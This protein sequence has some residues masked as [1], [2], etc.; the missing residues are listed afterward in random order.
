MQRTRISDLLLATFLI[1]NLI[2]VA[3]ALGADATAGTSGASTERLYGQDRIA[4]SI[5]ASRQGW[6]TSDTVILNELTNYADAISATPF[7]VQLD[8]PVLL[9]P[10]DKLDSRVIEELKR[11]KTKRIILLGGNG[12]LTT[13]IEK[14]LT[15]LNYT[16]ERIGGADRYE[17]SALIAQKVTSDSM[18]LVNG[19]DFPDALSA[20]SYAGIEQIPI[21]LMS[22]P[23]FPKSV[24]N[25]YQAKKPSQVIVVGGE[26]VVPDKLLEEQNIPIKVRLGGKDRYETD[27]LLYNYAQKSYTSNQLYLASGEQYPDAMV[28]TVLAAKN[29]SALL[30]T[31]RFEMP[32][33]IAPM[34]N[35]QKISNMKV[36]ILGGTGVVSGRIQAGIEGKD[37]NQVLLIGKTVVVDPGHGSPDPGA[38]GPSGTLEKDNNL[39]I[40]Q[41]L[42]E[43]LKTAGAKVVLSRTD[44]NSPANTAG[45]VYTERA[46]LQKR[47]DIA[48]ENNADLFISIHNDSWQTAHGTTTFYSSENPSYSSYKLAQ[49]IQSQ[50]TR[51]IGTQNLGVKDSRLYVLRNNTMPAVLVEVAFISYPTEEKLLADDAFRKKAAHGISQGVLQ[52]IRSEEGL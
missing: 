26:G 32:A 35:P 50:L 6:A 46:D 24:S 8:A 23:N 48:N 15:G 17:T 31:T 41:F 39:A 49:L 36:F 47:V 38:K 9:T 20:A 29:K 45:T 52:F 37:F 16:W 12:R 7:A 28:G 22:N 27:A 3:P 13:S 42:G 34:F 10:G 40:A 33:S 30:I 4:T 19:D 44:D 11:L 43:E 25:Y 1:F 14:E 18:I 21:L 51:E 2:P 5:A